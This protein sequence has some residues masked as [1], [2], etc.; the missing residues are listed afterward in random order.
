MTDVARPEGLQAQ[1]AGVAE[2]AQ[3]KAVD[4]A[5]TAAT[6]AQQRARE[7]AEE[8]KSAAAQ[9]IEDVARTVDEAAA[10][11]E[12]ALPQAA[13]YVRQAAS[14]VRA[15]SS[16][17]R[18]RSVDD[19]IDM[20]T[21]FARRRPAAVTSLS[22]FAG[23]AIARFLKAS[24]DRRE[25][26]SQGRSGKRQPPRRAAANVRPSQPASPAAGAPSSRPGATAAPATSG[27]ERNRTD[28]K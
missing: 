27:A 18:D 2:Q 14:T 12:R 19:L 3:T 20:A 16:A 7:L 25:T 24:A 13:P 26:G 10:A 22:L 8:Q 5:K 15:A 17:L 1:I 21:D 28:G 9:Q 23:F 11:V 4:L 6:A